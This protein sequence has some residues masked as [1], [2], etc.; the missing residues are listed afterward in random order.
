METSIFIMLKIGHTKEKGGIMKNI[1]YWQKTTEK[2]SYPSLTKN[3][4][5]DI[6]IIGGGITGIM[7]AYYLRNSG[8][9]IAVYEQGTLG[10]QTTG[11]TTGKI[12]FLHKTIYQFLMHYYSDDIAR[13]YLESNREAMKDIERIVETE[14]ISCDYTKNIAFVYTK[15]ENEVKYIEKEIAALKKLGV[16]IEEDYH[17]DKNI[18]K[19]VAVKD[20]AVFHPLKYIYDIVE[21]CRKSGIEFYENSKAIKF[22]IQKDV[23]TFVCNNN[24]IVSR[25][26]I[27]AT[28]YPQINYPQLYFL[29]MSQTREHVIYNHGLSKYRNSYVSID[30]PN[31]SFRPT[32]DGT[33]YAGYGHS[34]G[35]RTDTIKI[36]ENN[37]NIFKNTETILWSAQD[38]VT[39]RGIPYIGYFSSKYDH[40]YVACGYNKWGMTLSHVAAKLLSD[41]IL[42]KDNPYTCLYSPEYNNIAASIKPVGKL[43]KHSMKG[44]ITNRLAPLHLNV[45]KGEGKVVRLKGKLLAI[46]CDEQGQLHVC[47]PYC[48]HLKCIVSF[49]SLEK[50]WDCPCHGSRYDIDGNVLEGPAVTSLP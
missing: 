3:Q 48:R 32:V 7:C 35:E 47:K 24:E 27:F 29:K 43:I 28:R 31:E 26:T 18:K 17:Q 33:L 41:M 8:R 39:N 45:S 19:S 46:Y 21:I 14:N 16:Q 25:E 49:N 42:H 34:V 5:V 36:Q 4:K 38:S 1:S 44:M 13:M 11:H 30:N 50:T 9:K 12:T 20:Q 15:K 22:N 40:C 37:T 23:T 6:A 2:K 10:C